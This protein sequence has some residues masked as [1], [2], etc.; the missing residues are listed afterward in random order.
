M[1]EEILG[2]FRCIVLTPRDTLLN[3]STHSITLPAHDGQMGVWR[4]HMPM[5]CKLG[6]GIMEVHEFVTDENPQPSYTSFVIDGGFV[7]ISK[8][9]V[10]VLAY[11]VTGLSDIDMQKAQNMLD[12]ANKL[13]G[14]SAEAMNNRQHAIKKAAL[15]VQMLQNADSRGNKTA[16]VA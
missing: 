3:C 1:P 16:A 8:N 13:T 5:L 10:I 15:L 6:L 14:D 2:K 12:N 9:V 11:D 4:D 7:R